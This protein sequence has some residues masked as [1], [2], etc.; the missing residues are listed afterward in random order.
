M[1]EFPGGH[2][3]IALIYVIVKQSSCLCGQKKLFPG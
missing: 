2:V 1:E 3:K